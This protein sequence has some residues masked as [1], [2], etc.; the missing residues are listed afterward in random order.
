MKKIAYLECPTGIAGD[1]CLGALVHAGVP[2]D[3]LRLQL[4][5]LGISHEYHL[6]AEKIYHNGQVATKVHV[7]LLLDETLYHGHNKNISDS[8]P[9]SPAIDHSPDSLENSSLDRPPTST[10]PDLHSLDIHKHPPSHPHHHPHTHEHYNHEHQDRSQ[11]SR[12]R[13]LPEITQ[14]ITQADLPSRV[15]DWSLAVFQHLAEAEGAVHGVP[16][17]QVHFHEVGATDAIVDIVGTCLGLDWLNIEELYCSP[18][19][20]GGGTIWAAHGRL[21]VP[22]PAVLQLWQSRHCPIYSN[23]IEK[24]LVT[25]TGAALAVTLA[26]AF[27]APPTMHLHTIGLGAGS[28][29]LPIPNILRLWIGER[30]VING[31]HQHQVLAKLSHHPIP[32]SDQRLDSLDSLDSTVAHLNNSWQSPQIPLETIAVL[33]TQIDDLSPQA[34]SYACDRLFQIGALDV[35]TQ[36]ITMKKSRLGTLL[37]VIAPVV[38]I[39]ECEAVLFQE[40]STLGIRRSIQERS[41]LQREIQLV[42]TAYGVVRVKIAWQQEG[43]VTNVQ[44]EYE[45]CAAI[46]REKN[47]PWR[48]IHAAA[49]QKWQEIR[50]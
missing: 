44:P 2:L 12:H 31:E 42:Q 27:G 26:E 30:Q 38:K 14:L 33:E 48:Q 13:H 9:D 16:A 17:D 45:D 49:L 7:D 41:I 1:M 35:F 11:Q 46:A 6:R 23:G 25:P 10:K 50:V 22:V 8:R 32:Q 39:P 40:T 21:P 29:K 19:P 5:K 34:I 28:Q 18:L 20:T 36:G 24:E 37:T 47:L 43:G 15:K 3:Y 4:A